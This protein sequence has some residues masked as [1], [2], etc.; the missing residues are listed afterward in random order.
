MYEGTRGHKGN[1]GPSLTE[2]DYRMFG[3]VKGAVAEYI[4][5]TLKLHCVPGGGLLDQ[6]GQE[7]DRWRDVLC[8][9]VNER[10]EG[11]YTDVVYLD[12]LVKAAERFGVRA[13]PEKLIGRLDTPERRL[14]RL[15]ERRTV[16]T[17]N[18][19]M[20]YSLVHDMIGISLARWRQDYVRQKQIARFARRLHVQSVIIY[21]T[22]TLGVIAAL[23]SGG[24]G[25][26]NRY[27]EQN[28]ARENAVKLNDPSG[29]A[30]ADEILSWRCS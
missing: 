6:V 17:G 14:V 13:N 30:D 15:V 21:M 3:E 11:I 26:W 10:P 29:G 23:V 20:R 28:Y 25:F 5:A 24:L 18:E 8:E 27:A 1:W 2:R 4:S 9:M 22:G 16:E 7:V 12:E 19:I